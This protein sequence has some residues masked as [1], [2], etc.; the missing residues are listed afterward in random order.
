MAMLATDLVAK[1][2]ETLKEVLPGATRFGV[3]FTPA[4]PSHV[5]ALEASEKAAQTLGIELRLAPVH[6][7]RDFETVF[8][9]M[10]QDGSDAI[11]V[12]ATPLMMVNRVLIAGLAIRHRLPTAFGA[13][14]N[15]AAGGLMS[16]GPDANEAV[17]R[18]ATYIDKILKGSTPA[19]LPVEQASRYQLVFNL[20]TAKALGLTIPP[21]LL[22]RADEVIE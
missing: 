21:T 12:L 5:P 14:E 1:R 15:V 19:D 2:L 22:A 7:D 3:V 9:N 11:V 10:K 8:A 18:A 6:G 17:R 20:K 16:Y 4:V 13:K